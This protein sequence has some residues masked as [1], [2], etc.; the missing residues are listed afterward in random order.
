MEIANRVAAGEIAAPT[1][2][3]SSSSI[4][5]GENAQLSFST[6]VAEYMVDTNSIQL[7]PRKDFIV[8]IDQKNNMLF[9]KIG[10]LDVFPSWDAVESLLFCLR[11]H[12][13]EY[14]EEKYQE[15][16]GI[17]GYG[18]GQPTSLFYKSGA[19]D[20]LPLHSREAN[21]KLLTKFGSYRNGDAFHTYLL[22]ILALIS[23]QELFER[24]L[25][26]ILTSH[27]LQID[28]LSG[29]K[30]KDYLKKLNMNAKAKTE[31]ICDDIVQAIVTAVSTFGMICVYNCFHE[32]IY[33]LSTL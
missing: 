3:K 2:F 11:M 25:A 22:Q 7:S 4:K 27:S 12:N 29:N 15:L 31:M 17:I 20:I 1:G 32:I 13:A 19:T 23:S 6:L 30:K 16:G 18:R 14:S 26:E 21:T 9:P 28:S 10:W 24:I 5:R 33:I 8:K